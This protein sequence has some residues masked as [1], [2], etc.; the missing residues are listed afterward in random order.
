MTL[1][2]MNKTTS[3]LLTRW[4][5]PRRTHPRLTLKTLLRGRLTPSTRTRILAVQTVRGRDHRDAR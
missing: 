4:T 2:L 3:M 5:T 1:V